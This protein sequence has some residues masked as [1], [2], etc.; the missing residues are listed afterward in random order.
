MTKV[1]DLRFIRYANLFTS[2]TNIRTNHCFEYNNTLIFAVPREF[3]G[4]AIGEN[5]E[6][7]RELSILTNKKI[8]IVPIP[9]GIED[10]ENFVSIITKPV[11]FRAIEI[12]DNEAIITAPT[13]SKAALI[14]RGKVRMIELENILSQYFDIKKVRFK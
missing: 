4:R 10:I 6:N 12:K 1:L 14:G 5:N 9:S 8:K 11:K 2:V 7:L 13:Q 3:V